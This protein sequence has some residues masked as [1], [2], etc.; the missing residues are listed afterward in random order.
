MSKRILVIGSEGYLGSRLTDYLTVRGYAVVGLDTGFFRHGVAY[1]PRSVTQIG[2]DAR[3]IGENHLEGFD[4]VILLAGISN[5]PIGSLDPNLIYDPTRE[6]ALRI[7]KLC[8]KLGR[9]FIF[10][11][12]CSVYGIAEGTVDEDGPTDPQTPYSFNKLQIEQDLASISDRDF[13][14]I[15]LRLATVFGPSPRIRF[16]LVINMLCGMAVAQKRLLLNSDGA[17]W[18][19]HLYIEDACDAFK[20]CIDWDYNDGRLL[21]LNIGRND[22]NLRI[23]DVAN[24]VVNCEPG[25]ELAFLSREFSVKEHE[26]VKDRKLQDGVDKRT[27]KVN[28]DRAHCVLPNFS[29]KWTVGDGVADLLRKLHDLNLDT[30]KFYQRELYRL[31]QIEHLH[32]TGQL[33]DQLQWV[34]S[35]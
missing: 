1:C 29:A 12:S 34:F 23:I 26:L 7:A 24:I 16:D 11:S 25:A 2:I 8:K 30:T 14:P 5:D 4:V 19:P 31:Q 22:N 17:A 6:Y 18:R 13:S 21:V 35:N 28:F 15:A 3:V 9:R 27:Y 32:S 20:A 10:P 33:D